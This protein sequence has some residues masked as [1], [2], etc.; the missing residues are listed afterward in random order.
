M[1]LNLNFVYFVYLIDGKYFIYEMLSF[2]LDV[3][4]CDCEVFVSEINL[5]MLSIL[6]FVG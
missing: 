1:E 3:D 6:D 5:K 2:F 4:F